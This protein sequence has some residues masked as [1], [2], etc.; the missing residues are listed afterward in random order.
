MNRARATAGLC[1]LCALAISGIAA[2]GAYGAGTTAF[3]CIKDKG[4]L[5]GEHCLTTGGAPAEYGHVSVLENLTTEASA[6]S[7]KTQSETTESVTTLFKSTIGGVEVELGATE[8][9]GTGT[10]ENK[11]DPAGNITSPVSAR[12]STQGSR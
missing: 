4:N 6:T 10:M 2:Q 9:H 5:R 1:V 12:L 3:T 8:V 7:K 11:K